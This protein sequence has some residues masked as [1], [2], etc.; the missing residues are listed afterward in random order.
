MYKKILILLSAIIILS[1]PFQVQHSKNVQAEVI[2]KAGT[3]AAKKALKEVVE[4]I[5][6]DTAVNFALNEAVKI[7]NDYTL[8]SGFKMVCVDGS[9]SC[10]NPVQVK[11]NI[12]ADDKARI[13]SQAEIELDKLVSPN[14]KGF[15]KFE[16][17]LDW[18]L[19][20]WLVS[21]AFTAITY[22]LDGDFRSM[23][24]EVGYNT[25][26]ALGIVKPVTK[27][28][29][30]Q[31]AEKELNPQPDGSYTDSSGRVAMAELSKME[32]IVGD[33]G[34]T[35]S[36]Y[37][38]GGSSGLS[39]NANNSLTVLTMN[40]SDPSVGTFQLMGGTSRYSGYAYGFTG[41]QLYVAGPYGTIKA[42]VLF[43][44]KII[45]EGTP[46]EGWGGYKISSSAV[47]DIFNKKIKSIRSR[48]P[49]EVNGFVYTDVLY[50]TVEGDVIETQNVSSN[51]TLY[52]EV[53]SLN[54]GI[55]YNTP[56]K[57]S[58][59]FRYFPN[60]SYEKKI[61]VPGFA[62]MENQD[63]FPK[64]NYE[65]DNGNIALLPPAAMT[66]EEE[67][68]GEQVERKPKDGGIVFQKPDGTIVPDENV[69][70][71]P[72]DVVKNPGEVPSY[73]P[74]PTP[75]NPAPEPVPLTPSPT[76]S[77]PAEPHP[78]TT[79]TPEPNPNPSNPPGTPP[80]P[81]ETTEPYFP[82]GENCDVGLKIPKFL[83]LLNT[84]SET[85]PF[86]IPFDLAS[87]FDAIFAKMG[88]EQPQ[89]KFAFNV[90]EKDYSWDIKL[91]PLADQWKKFTDS[92]LIFIF[93]IAIVWAVFR[94]TGGGK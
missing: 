76:P 81:V 90:Q 47:N 10:D 40:Y 44:G 24:N 21:F 22:A 48:A 72:P 1:V 83:P 69:T 18:F 35:L 43:N 66:Y 33:S 41:S 26:V 20:I 62:E 50:N 88:K 46:T 9:T 30:L 71:K 25:L 74:S 52:N 80:P 3:M 82:E 61:L 59:D 57:F 60:V 13:K 63:V 51:P 53:R 4:D 5:A 2:T 67:G 89:F 37:P 78:G 65:D 84:I 38:A 58:A 68:T 92:F 75:S 23:L 28:L 42:V 29:D 49:Y 14:G 56:A 91:P 93:D 87:G 39:G 19:P 34:R 8:E 85:F 45:Y 79:P 86:S 73:T 6:V 12:T 11:E 7:V 64:S 36:V 27:N 16:N 15:S 94:F 17:F 55:V 54:M 31:E 32:N 70:V 77:T